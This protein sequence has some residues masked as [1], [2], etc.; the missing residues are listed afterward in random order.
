LV[1][2]HH[3]F[4]VRE[5]QKADGVKASNS[6]DNPAAWMREHQQHIAAHFLHVPFGYIEAVLSAQFGRLVR[7]EIR[8]NAE[9]A[10]QTL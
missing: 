8:G 10:S 4:K 3:L 9:K 7:S 6:Q 1:S 2:S 5:S